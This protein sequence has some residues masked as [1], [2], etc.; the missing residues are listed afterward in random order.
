MRNT[1]WGRGLGYLRLEPV[2]PSSRLSMA[3]EMRR[4]TGTAFIS[5][6]ESWATE[7]Y[8][9]YNTRACISIIVMRQFGPAKN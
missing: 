7:A 9:F 5:M 2:V 8:Y 6:K 1:I 4:G 3:N